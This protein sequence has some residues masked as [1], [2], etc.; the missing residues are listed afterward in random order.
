MAAIEL[1]LRGHPSMAPLWRLASDVLSLPDRALAVR[2]LSAAL[3]GDRGGLDALA[4][5]VAG[6]RLLT[7]SYSSSVVELVRLT[8]PETVLCMRSDPG[9]EGGHAAEATSAWTNSAMIEDDEA[10][11]DVPADLVVVGADAVTPVTVVNKVKTTALAEAA[12]RKGIQIH[13]VAGEFK[14][15]GA[16]LPVAPVFEAAPL[17]LFSAIA[18]P[19]GLWDPSQAGTHARSRRIHPELRPLL[20]EL[21]RESGD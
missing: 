8:R 3:E 15:V 9:G 2:R 1:L 7:I 16:K 14:F 6:L 19:Q 13:A 4:P 18:G 20:N 5:R 10:I 21:L 12:G 17:E 11:S